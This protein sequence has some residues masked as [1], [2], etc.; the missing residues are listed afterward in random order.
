MKAV[1]ETGMVLDANVILSRPLALLLYPPRTR[2]C[3]H[4]KKGKAKRMVD[5]SLTHF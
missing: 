2:F 4:V 3:F 1:Q 5:K